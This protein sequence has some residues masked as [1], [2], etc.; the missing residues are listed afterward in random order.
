MQLMLVPFPTVFKEAWT[1]IF[2]DARPPDQ[3]IP[4]IVKLK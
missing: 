3:L 2:I 4:T 1:L